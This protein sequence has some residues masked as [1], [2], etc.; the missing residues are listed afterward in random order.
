MGK[1]NTKI[2]IGKHMYY[3]NIEAVLA[4]SRLSWQHNV[5][6]LLNSL[7]MRTQSI[8]PTLPVDLLP[9]ILQYYHCHQPA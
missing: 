5:H 9:I 7:N 1:I 4:I 3:V 8:I 2:M 6:N